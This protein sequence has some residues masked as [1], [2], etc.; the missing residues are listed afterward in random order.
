MNTRLVYAIAILAV[1]VSA[2]SDEEWDG[3]VRDKTEFCGEFA[4]YAPDFC[5]KF[6]K[7]CET[8]FDPSNGDKC[9]VKESFCAPNDDRKSGEGVCKFSNCTELIT[10]T[11]TTTTPAPMYESINA[12]Y[13]AVTILAPLAAAL[14]CVM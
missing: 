8:Q 11:T 3:T 4:E 2:Q 9:Q 14:F 12:A 6:I 7:C 13:Q 10:T 5:Q 1:F